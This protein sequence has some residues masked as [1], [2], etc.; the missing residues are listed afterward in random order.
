MTRIKQ[1][2]K[3]SDG[4]P[5]R[6]LAGLVIDDTGNNGARLVASATAPD[7]SPIDTVGLVLLNPDGSVID[8]SNLGSSG[9]GTTPP[10]TGGGGGGGGTITTPLNL[11]VNMINP[12]WWI[13][14]PPTVDIANGETF[15]FQPT[16]ADPFGVPDVNRDANG[17]PKTLPGGATVFTMAFQTPPTNEQYKLQWDSA[18]GGTNQGL[19]S[20]E[21]IGGTGLSID[22]PNRTITFTPSDPSPQADQALLYLKYVPNSAA[23]Y[24]VNFRCRP[25]NDTGAFLQPSFQ[26]GVRA[27]TNSGGPIRVMDWTTVNRNNWVNDY[28]TV[29]YPVDGDGQLAEPIYTAAN[30]NKNANDMIRRDGVPVERIIS[31]FTALDRDIWY[32]LPWNADNTYYQ[33]VATKFAQFSISTG[34]KVYV[35]MSNEVWNGSFTVMHQSTNE[36]AF[37]SMAGGNFQRYCQKALAAFAAFESAYALLMTKLVRVLAWQNY[38]SPTVW[39]NAN[40]YGALAH[41]DAFAVAPYWGDNTNMGV[42]ANY[43]GDMAALAALIQADQDDTFTHAKGHLTKAQQYNKIL[44]FYETGFTTNLSDLTYKANFAKSSYM[45]DLELRA[46]QI[47]ERDFAG[48]SPLF[49]MCSYAYSYPTNANNNFAWGLIEYGS[50][51]I[52]KAAT[53]KAQAHVDFLNGIRVLGPALGSLNDAPPTAAAGFSLGVLQPSVYAPTWS[54]SN[55][56]GGRLTINPVTG[57]VTTTALFAGVATG[58]RSV[59]V[60]QTVNGAS[61]DTV[62]AYNV[63]ALFQDNFNDNSRDVTLWPTVGNFYEGISA[64]SGTANE[65][66]GQLQC[67]PANG[68]QGGTGY[69]SG[70]RDV[71]SKEYFVKCTVPGDI[72]SHDELAYLNVGPDADHHI[73]LRISS[74]RLTWFRRN[75]GNADFGFVT[76]NA[77]THAWLKVKHNGLDAWEFYT[78]PSTAANPP[79]S[80]DWVLQGTVPFTSDGGINAT[81]CKVAIGAYTWDGD[82]SATAVIFDAFNTAS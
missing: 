81:A 65:T 32:T 35:E 39:D 27:V 72:F 63:A 73:G 57:E 53:P 60:R 18:A 20:P 42:A 33:D 46:L 24:P 56:D 55:D 31:I 30:R 28:T 22:L 3:T 51:T 16:G 15:N 80:G 58:A 70:V 11:G 62:K 48:H 13:F 25:S 69:V 40:T 29:K 17:Y 14:Q 78:A 61:F 5:M 47:I 2:P 68:V 76:Y 26:N 59:T 74:N 79:A 49:A 1:Y 44:V 37:S 6:L 12:N 52:T 66:S 10:D 8:L 67:L 23:D 77:G 54:L 21:I 7:G 4:K 45:Y 43:T 9:G 75:A 41:V 19:H 71:T 34:H 82:R 50:Q 36:A 64:N 38:A